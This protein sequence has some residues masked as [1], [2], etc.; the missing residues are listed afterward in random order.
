[1]EL[2]DSVALDGGEWSVIDQDGFTSEDD[3]V[4]QTL[5]V[6][7]HDFQ[8]NDR[9]LEIH[10]DKTWDLINPIGTIE[11]SDM[12]DLTFPVDDLNSV[13]L[14]YSL[15]LTIQTAAGSGLQDSRAYI[16]E[17]LS[18]MNLPNQ[19]TSDTNGEVSDTILSK[20]YSYAAA[21]GLT[22]S[23][24]GDFALKVYRYSYSPFVAALS[25]NA[26]ISQPVILLPDV[27]IDAASSGDAV[28]NGLGIQV[29]NPTN[30]GT[31]LAFTAGAGAL[32]AGDSIEDLT[33]GATGIYV[34][35]ADGDLTDT[36]KIFLNTRNATAFAS[37]NNLSKQGGGWTGTAGVGR[38]YSWE[39]DCSGLSLQITYDYLAA[40]MAQLNPSTIYRSAIEWGEDE[41]SQL[42]YFGVNGYYTER[43]VN[44]TEGV[45][46]SNKGAGTIDYLTADN[47][48]QYTPPVQYTLSLVNLIEDSE[49]RIYR[50]SDGTEL[51]GT[52]SSTTSFDHNYTYTGAD[53][54]IY[55]HIHHLGYKWLRLDSVVL[56]NSD[57]TIPIQQIVDRDYE[58]P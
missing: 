5:E 29:R 12:S 11:E 49:V 53:V 46:A 31:L 22:I 24:R 3:G 42:V 4:T 57:Q 54:D 10:D 39:V 56:S 13:N 50:D 8:A 37:G 26:A 20:I 14:Q 36:G 40:R 51:G 27:G 33:S 6:A 48:Y 58:N 23:S 34:E 9:W 7:N 15:D 41:Q 19:N 32:S 52:E 47:G 2:I 35:L 21:S 16:Y 28:D 30:P 25:V 17:G 18:G 45:Y 44:L 55:I 43:N 38:D 1:M